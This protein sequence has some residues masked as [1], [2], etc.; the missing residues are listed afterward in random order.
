MQ[1][2]KTGSAA[3][4][5]LSILCTLL[6]TQLIN[7]QDK[8]PAPPVIIAGKIGA[9]PPSDAIVLFDGTDL[10]QWA[11]RNGDPVKWTIA[12][13]AVTC[14]PGSGSIITKEHFGDVQVHVEFATPLMA[15]KEG[16]DRGNS[17][18]YLQARY[19]VQILDSFEAETYSDGQCGAIYGQYP[20]LVNVC[21]PPEEWQTYD[22]VFYAPK[23]DSDGARTEPGRMTVFHNGVL[24]QHDV[25]LEGST[26]AS[27]W[28]EGPGD[29]PLYLQDHDNHV[30]YRNVWLRRLGS[31]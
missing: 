30:Q 12:D 6:S 24:I 15:D 5:I 7:A 17:G 23:F 25:E 31:Q 13:G 14:D 9:A 11:H 27:M 26:T 10:S 20:P 21:R 3:V 22:I 8:T 18:V 16:Q 4:A 29:G 1:A 19:E 2:M 28:K